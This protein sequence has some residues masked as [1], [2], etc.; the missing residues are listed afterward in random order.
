MFARQSVVLVIVGLFMTGCADKTTMGQQEPLNQH[1]D[2]QLLQAKD[3]ARLEIFI[4]K[5]FHSEAFPITT[6]PISP[7]GRQKVKRCNQNIG[8]IFKSLQGKG[9]KSIIVEGLPWKRE[10]SGNISYS[11]KDLSAIGVQEGA[12]D[13]TAVEYFNVYGA[14]PFESKEI[15]KAMLTATFPKIL[16]DDSTNRIQR[17][18][19]TGLIDKAKQEIDT[20]ADMVFTLVRNEMVLDVSN[21]YRSLYSLMRAVHIANKDRDN[22]IAIVMGEAHYEDYLYVAKKLPSLKITPVSCSN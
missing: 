15:G 21:I 14:E 4:I 1:W 18:I 8:E 3:N 16:F 22:K 2:M 11:A 20:Q 9:V 12:H 19:E 10:K 13:Y 6:R 17:F 5:H 7:D